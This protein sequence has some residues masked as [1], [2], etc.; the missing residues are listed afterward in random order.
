MTRSLRLV[1][2]AIV[3]G[4]TSIAVWAQEGPRDAQPEPTR[5]SPERRQPRPSDFGFEI[6]RADP[7]RRG[8]EREVAEERAAK[9]DHIVY[10]P[11]TAPASAL[12]ETLRNIFDREPGVRIIAEPVSNSLV[13]S[14]PERLMA[15]V[16]RLLPNLDRER[17]VLQFEVL[18]VERKVPLQAGDKQESPEQAEP[19]AGKIEEVLSRVGAGEM[20]GDMTLLNRFSLTS[21]EGQKAMAQLGLRLPR[22][23][24]TSITQRG[25]ANAVAMENIGTM[26]QLSSRLQPDGV[27]VVELEFEKSYPGGPEEATVILEDER[28]GGGQPTTTAP[29]HSLIVRQTLELKPGEFKPLFVSREKPAKGADQMEQVLLVGVRGK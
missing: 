19:L 5:K 20:K 16:T 22:I 12:A 2:A 24:G 27:V 11:R 18:L 21:V 28:P 9:N 1:I 13:I 7:P 10:S 17:Q 4:L 29:I 26:L 15:E 6:E 3:I 23:T 14:A 25:R 8:A